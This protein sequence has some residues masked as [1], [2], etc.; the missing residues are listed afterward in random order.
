MMSA[1][2]CGVSRYFAIKG[3]GLKGFLIKTAFNPLIAAGW[4]YA[5]LLPKDIQ[6]F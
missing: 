2:E 6:D 1:A 3:F 5:Q 4:L